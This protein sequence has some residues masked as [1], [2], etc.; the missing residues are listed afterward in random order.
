M[1][2]FKF[3]ALSLLAAVAPLS[4]V[5]VDTSHDH[6]ATEV[7]N[8]SQAT[9]DTVVPVHVHGDI[10]YGSSDAPVEVVEY[11]SMTCHA[12]KAFYDVVFKSLMKTLIPEGKVKLV[13]RNFVRDRADLAVAILT[14]CTDDP[15]K[16]KALIASFFEKQHEWAHSPQ[17]GVAIK[18]LANYGGVSLAR[19]NECGASRE[20]A[21]HMIEMQQMGVRHYEIT[22][23]PTVLINGTKVSFKDFDELLTKI[24]LATVGK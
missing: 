10:V 22:G 2:V 20:I 15:E 6:K 19:I 14:R 5:A 24:E 12:C 9:D 21:E 13:F 3:V 16:T 11:A 1:R 23:T 17:I 8:I 7:I 18:S 4:A